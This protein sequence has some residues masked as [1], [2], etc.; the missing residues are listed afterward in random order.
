VWLPVQAVVVLDCGPRILR[1]QLRQ[2]VRTW[3]LRVL[4]RWIDAYSAFERLE[5]RKWETMLKL[6]ICEFAG[7]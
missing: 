7:K 3:P 1:F 2:E 6:E 4:E 5:Y